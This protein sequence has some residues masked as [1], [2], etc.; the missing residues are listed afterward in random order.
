MAILLLIGLCHAY[1]VWFGDILVMYCLAGMILFPLRR[2]PETV[3]IATG[4]CCISV[5]TLIDYCNYRQIF[6]P[7]L[8]VTDM[9][10]RIVSSV[11]GNDGEIHAYRDGWNA[12]MAGRAPYSFDNETTS[13]ALHWLSLIHI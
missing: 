8:A 4:V 3:L 11:D 2:L 1:F 6:P 12:E 10:G 5:A 7:V 13:F 9:S